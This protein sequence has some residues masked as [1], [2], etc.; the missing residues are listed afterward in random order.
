MLEV[1]L[2]EIRLSEVRRISLPRTPMNKGKKKDRTP[3]SSGPFLL[4][5]VPSCKRIR[6]CPLVPDC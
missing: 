4:L 3:R 6:S 5:A 1:N 2:R